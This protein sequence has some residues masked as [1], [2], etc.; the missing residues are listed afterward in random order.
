MIATHASDVTEL[1]GRHIDRGEAQGEAQAN[2][3]RTA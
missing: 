1:A 3:L 2:W